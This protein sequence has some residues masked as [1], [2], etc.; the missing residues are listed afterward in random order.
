MKFDITK[1]TLET[2]LSSLQPFLEK[3]DASQITA[4]IFFTVNDKELTLKATDREMGLLIS[5][6]DFKNGVNGSFTC[7]GQKI[8]DVVRTLHPDEISVENSNDDVIIKQKRTKYKLQSFNP[9]QFPEFEQNPSLSG[10]NINS[11][12]LITGFK[13]TFPA[14]AGAAHKAELTGTL[15]DIKNSVI[16][17]VATDTKRLAI[18]KIDQGSD[19]NFSFILPKRA[20]SEIQKVF[21]SDFSVAF[22]DT[23]LI[24]QNK[25]YYFFTKVI[26]GRFPDYERIIPREINH[27]FKVNT[28]KMIECLL[29]ISSLSREVKIIFSEDQISFETLEHSNEEATTSFEND[30]KIEK[31]FSIAVDSR[32]LIEFLQ[33]VNSDT[34]LIGVNEP[35]LPFTLENGQLLTI[36]MPIIL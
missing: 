34:F 32:F 16:N 8:L 29:Q 7:N 13:Q 23:N 36:V 5:T 18:F 11:Q 4:H 15:V 19:K 17:I 28:K 25:D 2:M 24:V 20:V 26:N 6:N 12:S 22:D 21:N 9:S 31:P 3:K 10:I 30:I 14:I 27:K 33:Q 35:T 1:G